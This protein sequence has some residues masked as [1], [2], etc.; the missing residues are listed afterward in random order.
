MGMIQCRKPVRVWSASGKW[1]IKFG[2]DFWESAGNGAEHLG[3]TLLGCS[4]FTYYSRIRELTRKAEY[5]TGKRGMRS[6]SSYLLSDS[7]LIKR[8]IQ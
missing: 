7:A 3:L 6:D 1:I 4:L 8:L 2:D 5:C